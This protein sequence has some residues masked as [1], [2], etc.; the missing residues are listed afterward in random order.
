MTDAGKKIL[1][2]RKCGVCMDY[3]SDK[4]TPKKFAN[5]SHYCCLP[6]YKI[7]H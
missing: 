7:G 5:C 1:E 2:D 6:C 3:Y 4:K